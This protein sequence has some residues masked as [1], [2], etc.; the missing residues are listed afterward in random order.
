MLLFYFSVFSISRICISLPIPWPYS[1]LRVPISLPLCLS[2]PSSPPPGIPLGLTPSSLFLYP[3][4][5][6][7]SKTLSN[8]P[9]G[10]GILGSYSCS[11]SETVRGRR[12]GP[13]GG[14]SG[15]VRVSKIWA[16]KASEASVGA[17]GLPGR[18]VCSKQHKAACV[19][20]F[21][22]GPT[23]NSRAQPLNGPIQPLALWKV[24]LLPAAIPLW[25]GDPGQTGCYSPLLGGR[26]RQVV[27]WLEPASYFRPC[28][29]LSPT[30]PW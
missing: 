13:G 14:G 27:Q 6:L 3:V 22:P 1:P 16:S 23:G 11:P 30:L 15:V 5:P 28:P 9:P 18:P 17:R 4:S 10:T 21:P 20:P 8:C 26:W 12:R 29:V 25:P 19:S 24:P 2:I 7:H